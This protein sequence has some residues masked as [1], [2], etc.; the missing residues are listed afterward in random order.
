MAGTSERLGTIQGREP[1]QQKNTQI[2]YIYLPQISVD[3]PSFTI[4]D[5]DSSKEVK[6]SPQAEPMGKGKNKEVQENIFQGGYNLGFEYNEGSSFSKHI[7]DYPKPSAEEEKG[8]ESVLL[9]TE[10]NAPDEEDDRSENS[11]TMQG[12]REFG[13]TGTEGVV[14]EEIESP[15]KNESNLET[16]YIVDPVPQTRI[17]KDH[18]LENI[19]GEVQSSVQTR[20]I[21][22]NFNKELDKCLITKDMSK[23]LNT[24][25]FTCFLSQIEP[26]KW[27]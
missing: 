2:E 5:S 6:A 27:T 14:L 15:I 10:L 20:S 23:A 9:E 4:T 8:I 13:V 3:P 19:L 16:E 17:H 22:K 24:C 26:K 1:V 11:D 25:L 18:P 7:E 21:V 12:L